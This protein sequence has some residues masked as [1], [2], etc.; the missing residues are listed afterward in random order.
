ML[1]ERQEEIMLFIQSYI[2]EN[3]YAPSRMDIANEFDFGVNAAHQHL[4]AIAKKGFIS[5]APKVPRGMKIVKRVEK[6]R[7]DNVFEAITDSKE[8]AA[9]MKR[10]ADKKLADRKRGEK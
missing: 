4:E 5:I 6:L 9:Q 10:D 7:F 3:S 2:D 8:E 1:T